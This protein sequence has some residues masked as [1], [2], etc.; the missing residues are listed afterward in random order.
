MEFIAA[1]NEGRAK[2]TTERDAFAIAVGS[3]NKTF[4]D[5]QNQVME[6]TEGN[7]LISPSIDNKWIIAYNPSG[8]VANKRIFEIATWSPDLIKGFPCTLSIHN[9]TFT[10][11]NLKLLEDA[12]NSMISNKEISA[13]LM[14]IENNIENII[15]IFDESYI[16]SRNNGS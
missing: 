14:D 1:F 6:I 11:T 15:P 8:E 3:V 7:L 5:L 4:S 13:L 10:C 2:A 12:V 16:A 9:N